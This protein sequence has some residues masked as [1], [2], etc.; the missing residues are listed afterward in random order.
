[1]ISA[2]KRQQ[3]T[4]SH[5]LSWSTKQ[6]VLPRRIVCVREPTSEDNRRERV[7]TLFR[8]HFPRRPRTGAHVYQFSVWLLRNDPE[9]LPTNR[10][11]FYH[12]L[13]A[14]LKGLWHETLD[15]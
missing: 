11:T 9:L 10:G 5:L 15:E 1:V 13:K 12:D 7:R 8:E 3:P 6:R 14:A 2:Y 4:H